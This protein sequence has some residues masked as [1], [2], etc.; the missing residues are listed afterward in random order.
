MDRRNLRVNYINEYGEEAA[1]GKQAHHVI[2]VEVLTEICNCDEAG[3]DEE[4]NKTWNCLMLPADGS[5]EF[6][7]RGSHPKY[8]RFIRRTIED[9]CQGNITLD[10]IKTVA[11]IIRTFCEENMQAFVSMELNGKI[12]DLK[13]YVQV[14]EQSY[15]QR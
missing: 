3:L 1:R 12:D 8:T 5:G 9:I 15:S 7:H 10:G 2:P 4:Y 11:A 13:T 14:V 6:V